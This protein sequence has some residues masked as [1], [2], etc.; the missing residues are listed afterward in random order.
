VIRHSREH[1]AGYKV[2]RG[3]EFREDLPKSLIGKILRKDL[4]AEL[5]DETF[6]F[7][8]ESTGAHR[9]DVR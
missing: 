1:L 5:P 6:G 2:P 3:V 8:P 7:T 9:E 4:R